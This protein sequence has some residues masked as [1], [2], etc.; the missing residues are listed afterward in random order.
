VED[1][2]SEN[3]GLELKAFFNQYLR[4]TK[5]PKLEYNIKDG[6]LNYR[7]TNI[8]DGFTLPLTLTA[9]DTKTTIRPTA[10]WQ[11][12]NWNGGYNVEFSKDFLIKVKL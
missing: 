6:K 10:E 3:T 8:T 12:I 4:T 9:C 5:I 7:F 1:Y 11:Q 2:I